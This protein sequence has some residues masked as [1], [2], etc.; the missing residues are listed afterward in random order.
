M[1]SSQTEAD[2]LKIVF[3]SLEPFKAT[4]KEQHL[5]APDDELCNFISAEKELKRKNKVDENG[6]RMGVDGN[7]LL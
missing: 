4:S 6:K 7:R 2:A 1:I 5:C 3:W